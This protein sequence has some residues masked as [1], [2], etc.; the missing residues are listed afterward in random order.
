MSKKTTTTKTAKTAPVSKP[1][2]YIAM[3]E[4]EEIIAQGTWDDIKMA[5][6]DDWFTNDDANRVNRVERMLAMSR[7][8]VEMLRAVMDRVKAPQERHAMLQAMR[9]VDEEVAQHDHFDGLQ[10]P[11]LRG[12]GCEIGRA[13]V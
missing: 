13:H 2:Y 1:K 11:R 5:I 9:P 8:P 3:L 10:P 7:E 12:D 6:E 4:N